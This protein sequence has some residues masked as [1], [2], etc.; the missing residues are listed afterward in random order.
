MNRPITR[1]LLVHILNVIQRRRLLR[2]L[3]Q[4]WAAISGNKLATPRRA[5]VALY[6]R[7]ALP[8]V[9]Q[10]HHKC[11]PVNLFTITLRTLATA[12][13]HALRPVTLLRYV[14]K[15]NLKT[16]RAYPC[17]PARCTSCW[18]VRRN[19][20][21]RACTYHIL[22]NRNYR[23]YVNR[24]HRKGHHITLLTHTTILCLTTGV[25][26][27]RFTWNS[28]RKARQSH[29]RGGIIPYRSQTAAR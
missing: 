6:P 18:T 26:R 2:A 9:D 12:F 23:R 14:A 22:R 25:I 24:C 11:L 28:R 7:F 21:R 10:T 13:K 3:I 17:V 16:W 8:N 27:C 29:V 4:L 5:V 20:H 1:C 15:C 19:R